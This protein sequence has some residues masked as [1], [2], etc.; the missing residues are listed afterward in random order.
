VH[1][2]AIAANK[3]VTVEKFGN[4][5]YDLAKICRTKSPAFSGGAFL[6]E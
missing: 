3:K 1:L 6:F 2:Y 4:T 5:L